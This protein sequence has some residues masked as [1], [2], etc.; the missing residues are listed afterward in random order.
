MLAACQSN[1][2]NT[3]A[4]QTKTEAESTINA[5]KDQ[6][7]KQ[8]KKQQEEREKKSTK[9]SNNTTDKKKEHHDNKASKSDDTAKSNH[10]PQDY[11]GKHYKLINVNTCEGIGSMQIR[12]PNAVVDIGHGKRKYWA[13]TNQY[14]QLVYVIANKIKLQTEKEEA[15]TDHDGRYCYDEAQ[16][17]GTP[18]EK[19]DQGHVIADS[20][21]GASNVYNITPQGSRLNRYGKQAD[22]ESN[23][24]QA[25]GAIDFKVVIEYSNNQ[26]MTPSKYTF[27]YV[28]G[29][30]QVKTSFKNKRKKNNDNITEKE[31]NNSNTTSSDGKQSIDVNK[32]DANNNGTITIAEAEEAGFSMPIKE[33]E[34]P[35]IYR[36]MIDG[37]GDG[38]VGE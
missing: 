30:D 15:K 20:L 37:D 8:D 38:M 25:S 2:N 6:D 3:S 29:G 31:D 24:R 28:V 17:E 4:Q 33:K 16:I 5:D 13:Y 23:I 11:K 1:S 18:K 21:G 7:K 27:S 34:Y 35:N 9:T 32:I 19:L 14:G 10:L 22:M 26:T 12:Q 36:M